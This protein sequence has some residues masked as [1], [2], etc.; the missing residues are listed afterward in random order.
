VKDLYTVKEVLVSDAP[1]IRLILRCIFCGFPLCVDK[2]ALKQTQISLSMMHLQ[3]GGVDDARGQE[4][5]PY[6]QFTVWSK[7]I[8]SKLYGLAMRVRV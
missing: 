6:Y 3:R 2:F 5:Y 7:L 8:N 4:F 1:Q